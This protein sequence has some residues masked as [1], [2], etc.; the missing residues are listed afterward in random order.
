MEAQSKWQ[1]QSDDYG[2]LY[3]YNTI[4]GESVW[5]LPEEEEE[6]EVVDVAKTKN[7]NDDK[8]VELNRPREQYSIYAIA[9]GVADTLVKIVEMIEDKAENLKK[10]KIR[11]KFVSPA[12]EQRFLKN[13]AKEEKKKKHLRDRVVTAYVNVLVPT[14]ETGGD[15][16]EKRREVGSLFKAEES[17]R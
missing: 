8:V 14:I 1:V 5:Q 10:S 15:G 2:N 11:R 6:V 16:G 3:F 12:A 9:V 13:A 7:Q 4:T 17:R